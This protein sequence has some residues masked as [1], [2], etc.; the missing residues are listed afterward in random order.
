MIQKVGPAFPSYCHCKCNLFNYI[1]FMS[2]SLY[3]NNNVYNNI[4]GE[5]YHNNSKGQHYKSRRQRFFKR[6]EDF[7]L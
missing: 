3:F 1:V 7:K 2:S 5:K 6:V 4:I